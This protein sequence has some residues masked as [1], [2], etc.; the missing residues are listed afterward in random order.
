MGFDFIGSDI[1]I[2]YVE[3]NAKRRGKTPFSNPNNSFHIFQHDIFQEWKSSQPEEVF[4]GVLPQLIVTEGWLGPIITTASKEHDIIKAQD[5]VM[6]LYEDFIL[7][8]HTLFFHHKE[9]PVIVFTIPVYTG[10]NLVE[11]MLIQLIKK[12]NKWRQIQSIPE[13]YQR[14][15]QKIGRKIIIIKQI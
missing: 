9:K 11:D 10:K 14:E 2:S 7:Q 8:I 3:Q 6:R 4:D 12:L 5:E 1:N 15:N 13:I